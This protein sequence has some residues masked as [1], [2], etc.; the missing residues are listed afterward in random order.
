DLKLLKINPRAS[1]KDLS[2]YW[3]NIIKKNNEEN[4]NFEFNNYLEA[5]RSY[6]RLVNEYTIIK[7]CITKLVYFKVDL[8]V[9]QTLEDF[10]YRV[11]LTKGKKGFDESLSAIAS[12]S[13][14]LITKILAKRKEIERYTTKKDGPPMTFAKAIM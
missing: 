11:D 6:A 13:N 4:G 7:A 2:L 14:N 3:E 12:R 1:N 8:N 10:G 5:I 9:V